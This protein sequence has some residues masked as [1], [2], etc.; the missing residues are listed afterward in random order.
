MPFVVELA[1]GVV[2]DAEGLTPRR[3]DGEACVEL[4]GSMNASL[5]RRPYDRKAVV[6]L[7]CMRRIRQDLLIRYA[8]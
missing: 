3:S 1:V 5:L 8:A 2:P 7:K 6:S 4:V